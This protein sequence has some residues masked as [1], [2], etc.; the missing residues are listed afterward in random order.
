MNMALLFRRAYPHTEI[1]MYNVCTCATPFLGKYTDTD[2]V[3]QYTQKIS[4]AL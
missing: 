2:N 4:A 3:K 1:M